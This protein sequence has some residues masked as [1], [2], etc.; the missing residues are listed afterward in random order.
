MRRRSFVQS[1]LTV[2][3]AAAAPALRAQRTYPNK[4]ITLV[5]PFASGGGG[6]PCP[7]LAKGCRAHQQTDRRGEPGRR[8][9]QP[10]ARP[11]C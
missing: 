11:S 2:G 1:A 8:R 7:L 3:L 10:S 4:P 5:V 9:R 6:D